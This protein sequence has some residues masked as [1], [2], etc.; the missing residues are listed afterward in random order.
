MPSQQRMAIRRPVVAG[1]K[2]PAQL[3][4]ASFTDG[5][6]MRQHGASAYLGKRST[7]S[8]VFPNPPRPVAHRPHRA[9]RRVKA[10]LPAEGC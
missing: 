6:A 4:S 3:M 5:S 8:P 10:A 1:A 7:I 9:H 2:R